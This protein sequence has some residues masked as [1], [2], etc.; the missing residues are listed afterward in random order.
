M[1]AK[2][3]GHYMAQAVS[4]WPLTTE[5]QAWSFDLCQTCGK[6]SGNGPGLFPSTSDLPCQFH[7]TNAL[8]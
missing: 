5:A 4:L 6:Q 7:S 8:Y 3:H 2:H 1:P